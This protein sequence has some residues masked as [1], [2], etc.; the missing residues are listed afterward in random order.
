MSPIVQFKHCTLPRHLPVA[1]IYECCYSRYV[2]LTVTYQGKIP[3]PSSSFPYGLFT[4]PNCQLQWPPFTVQ[5]TACNTP[6]TLFI[7]LCSK[8]LTN[9]FMWLIWD[10]K[11]WVFFVCCPVWKIPVNLVVKFLFCSPGCWYCPHMHI[12]MLC[13]LWVIGRH[14]R[15]FS[16]IQ[17]RGWLPVVC[18]SSMKL[19]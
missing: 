18:Y 19:T 15:L 7:H 2:C 6:L 16:Y 1:V 17:L 4:D 8:Q 12:R 9:S 10:T 3:H 11:L 5:I 14:R 13:D